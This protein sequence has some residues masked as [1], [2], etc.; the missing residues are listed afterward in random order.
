[1]NCE[2]PFSEFL[3]V[4]NWLIKWPMKDLD[5]P[6]LIKYL[7]YI[8]ASKAL[9]PMLENMKID[10]CWFM[11]PPGIIDEEFMEIEWSLED[12]CPNWRTQNAFLA[13]MQLLRRKVRR[14]KN[15]PDTFFFPREKF[16][17]Y[18]DHNFNMLWYRFNLYIVS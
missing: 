3:E 1:M 13:I 2:V 10:R 12:L 4:H 7:K 14:T 11:F 8:M 9:L 6:G 18:T 16:L 15:S 5:V 17:I